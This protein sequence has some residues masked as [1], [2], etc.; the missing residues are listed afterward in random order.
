MRISPDRRQLKG[1]GDLLLPVAL[2]A[3]GV[4]LSR[5]GAMSAMFEFRGPDTASE[6]NHHMAVLSSRLNQVLRDLGDGWML[7]VDAIR[8]A[9]PG[10]CPE[11]HFPDT[12]SAIIDEERRQQFLSEG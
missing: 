3:D 12:A 1:I 4:N 10:Y 8:F 6:T 9:S 7:Q 11:G 5:D 2:A